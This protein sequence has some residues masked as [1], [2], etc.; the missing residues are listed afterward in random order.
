[1]CNVQIPTESTTYIVQQNVNKIL[2][3]RSHL[4]KHHTSHSDMK[5][6]GEHHLAKNVISYLHHIEAGRW[7][8]NQINK[9][10]YDGVVGG[11]TKLS[12]L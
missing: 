8:K 1:M 5:Y 3:K 4:F 11:F 12:E 7:K 10:K 6:C 9:D 2:Y